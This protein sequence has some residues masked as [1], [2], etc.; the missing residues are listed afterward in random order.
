MAGLVPLA[1]QPVGE[2]VVEP[3]PQRLDE[4]AHVLMES[5]WIVASS[6]R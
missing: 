5:P 3:P 1:G 6:R 2:R 4:H